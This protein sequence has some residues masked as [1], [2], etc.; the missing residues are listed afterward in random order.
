[1]K[2][3]NKILLSLL[4]WSSVVTLSAQNS[5]QKA[6]ETQKKEITDNIRRVAREM[7]TLKADFTQVKELS[8]MKDQVTSEGKMLYKPN[9]K[10]R[11][12]Y[13]RPYAYVFAMDGDNVRMISG[14]KTNKIPVRGSKLFTEISR[15]MIGGV[16]GAGLIDSPDFA[17][18]FMIGKSDCKIMLT[19]RKKEVKD[20]FS[21]I[22]LYVDRS[23]SRI[24]RVELIEKSGDKTIIT[25]K[26]IQLNTPVDDSV[27]AH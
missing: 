15:V 11:W 16:S 6:T 24:R 25:L 26:N 18:A 2:T 7:K 27:F 8:F 14:G 21:S 1:M 10:I 5:Y 17:T 9:D 13:T 3:T 4:M 23:D 20:L 19:P 12:E 22:Q